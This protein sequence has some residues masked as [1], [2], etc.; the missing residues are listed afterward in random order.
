[1]IASPNDPSA[2][3]APFRASGFETP[4]A[5]DVLTVALNRVLTRRAATDAAYLHGPL[6]LLTD[7]ICQVCAR[8]TRFRG[9]SPDGEVFGPEFWSDHLHCVGCGLN[10]QARALVH[11]LRSDVAGGDRASLAV[12]D[13]SGALESWVARCWP[14]RTS[15]ARTTFADV[16][17]GVGATWKTLQ[18]AVT[19]LRP[20]GKILCS[21]H[22]RPALWALKAGMDEAGLIDWR[23]HLYW[24]EEF[25]YFG[26]DNFLVTAVFR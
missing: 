26:A 23:A 3:V 17:L 18:A 24:S 2:G 16:V 19:A 20:G 12:T 21:V 1:M 25:G 11:F 15:A 10:G 14:G 9:E 5:L 8:R 7:G 6:P 4:E 13:A 22:G